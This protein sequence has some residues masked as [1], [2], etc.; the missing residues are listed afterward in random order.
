MRAWEAGPHPPETPLFW[1]ISSNYTI[2]NLN[3]LP[4]Q[5]ASHSNT[6]YYPRNE[7]TFSENSVILAHE[8][9]KLI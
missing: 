4:T 7:V 8:H 2:V 9:P 6:M 5:N 1:T 3:N